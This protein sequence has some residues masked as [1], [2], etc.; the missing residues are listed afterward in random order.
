MSSCG[1]FIQ[2]GHIKLP[3]FLVIFHTTSHPFPLFHAKM[4]STSQ[5]VDENRTLSPEVVLSTRTSPSKLVKVSFQP[6]LDA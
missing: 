2:R 3:S 5:Q 1:A 4:P 6:F